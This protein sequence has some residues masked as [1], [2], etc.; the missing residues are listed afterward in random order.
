MKKKLELLPEVLPEPKRTASGDGGVRA[1]TLVHMQRLLAAAAA[2]GTLAGCTREGSLQDDHHATTGGSAVPTAPS[3]AHLDLP[4][5]GN[6]TVVPP[7][8]PP[9]STTTSTGYAVVDPVPPPAACPGLATEIH[10]TARWKKSAGGSVVVEVVLPAST[11][12]DTVAYGGGGDVSVYGGTLSSAPSPG[13][14]QSFLVE[15]NPGVSSVSVSVSLKCNARPATLSLGLD[16]SGGRVIGAPVPVT[17]S[18]Y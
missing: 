11:G 17:V 8:P 7:V 13:S 4:D 16:V 9:T 5:A 15:P 3:G 18:S 12:L 1:R 10:A 14:S 2:G 6:W